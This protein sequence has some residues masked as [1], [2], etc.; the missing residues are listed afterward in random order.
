MLSANCRLASACFWISIAFFIDRSCRSSIFF[1][2]AV[3]FRLL[4]MKRYW[5]SS[6]ILRA[7]RAFLM[8]SSENFSCW[9]IERS[10]ER[11]PWRMRISRSTRRSS[12]LLKRPM[13]D[14]GGGGPSSVIGHER[15]DAAGSLA[16]EVRLHLRRAGVL[17]R[18][19]VGPRQARAG[20]HALHAEQALPL[21]KQPARQVHPV[22]RP[23]PFPLRPGGR[24][25]RI[26]LRKPH[27]ERRRRPDAPF[28]PGRTPSLA[29]RHERRRAAQ[30]QQQAHRGRGGDQQGEEDEPGELTQHGEIRVT[31]HPPPPPGPIPGGPRPRA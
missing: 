30:T 10:M 5:P 29:D 17:R 31:R 27:L 13:A 11:I 7:W 14:K 16:P 8:K 26:S 4:R 20:I 2:A 6:P 24:L 1:T 25:D 21:P 23:P 12:L 18:H 9:R 22:L 3:F 28:T 15:P 19:R